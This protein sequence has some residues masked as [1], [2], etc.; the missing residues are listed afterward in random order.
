MQIDGRK[1]QS[2]AYCA[3]TKR[4]L[5]FY[6]TFFHGDLGK[7]KAEDTNPLMKETYG[8]LYER[9]LKRHKEYENASYEVIAI[10]EID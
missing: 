10:W 3:D 8:Y 9:T 2:D 6:G 5:E 7:Y 1:Y 4:V